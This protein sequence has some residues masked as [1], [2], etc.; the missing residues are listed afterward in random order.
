MGKQPTIGQ[1]KSKESIAKAA[2][3][4]RK[5]LKKK[6]S[7]GRVTEKLNLSVIILPSLWKNIEKDIGFMKIITIS[8]VSEKF[9]IVASMARKVI[10]HFGET[11]LIQPLQFQHQQCLVFKGTKEKK[12]NDDDGKKK[13]GKKGKKGKK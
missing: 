4:S 6:W 3:M 5:G 9:K 2:S 11:G 12:K 8:T 10:R 13:K 7:K 1:K